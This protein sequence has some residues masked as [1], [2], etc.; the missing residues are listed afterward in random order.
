MSIQFD[1]TRRRLVAKW[2]SG[3][4]AVGRS[5]LGGLTLVSA[6]VI[7]GLWVWFE[8]EE[9]GRYSWVWVVGIAA[10]ALVLSVLG[11]GAATFVR[12]VAV[13]MVEGTVTVYSRFLRAQRRQYP[14]KT[15]D[16]I[17][18]ETQRRHRQYEHKVCLGVAGEARVEDPGIGRS[19]SIWLDELADEAEARRQA[20]RVAELWGLAPEADK[21]THAAGA[22]RAEAKPTSKP[23]PEK[24][25]PDQEIVFLRPKEAPHEI[26]YGIDKRPMPKGEDVGQLLPQR[27]GPFTL[28]SRRVTVTGVNRDSIDAMYTKS[29]SVVWLT[30]QVCAD[31]VTAQSRVIT[32]QSEMDAEFPEA[33]DRHLCAT[34]REPS[35]FKSVTEVHAFLG[36]TRGRYYFS[37]Q[38]LG[39]EAK[40][41]RFMESFPY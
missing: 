26:P 6:M 29:R 13:D 36:W 19:R 32:V 30:L 8:L 14:L 12:R 9:G 10:V 39:G 17:L 40:L 24:D 11:F 2:P 20:E 28:Y 23:P 4:L 18:I 25:S 7:G 41:D 31:A 15:F 34:G 22:A 33:A 16:R 35:Y 1:R 21:R 27:V 38:A 3:C 5:L 37:A